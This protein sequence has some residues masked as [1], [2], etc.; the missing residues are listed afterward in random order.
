MAGEIDEIALACP[1]LMTLNAKSD[2]N[3]VTS[4]DL[5]VTSAA[6]AVQVMTGDYLAT[7]V[8]ELTGGGFI[9]YSV[10]RGLLK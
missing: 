5:D 3:P 6:A 10:L 8:Q 7:D 1:C 4:T 9:T 2:F